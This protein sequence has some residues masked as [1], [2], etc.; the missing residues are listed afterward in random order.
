MPE[1]TVLG[2]P[3][4]EWKQKQKKDYDIDHNPQK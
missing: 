1:N 4:A 2:Q 3:V